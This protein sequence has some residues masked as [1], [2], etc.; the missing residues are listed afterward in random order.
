MRNWFIQ[1]H[2]LKKCKFNF[3]AFEA[4]NKIVFFSQISMRL[5]IIMR[6]NPLLDYEIIEFI[7][8]ILLS[9]LLY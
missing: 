6:L 5:T 9:Y 8:K 7:R 1:S 4:G 3:P 2:T